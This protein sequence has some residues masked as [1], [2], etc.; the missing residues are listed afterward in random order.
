MHVNQALSPVLVALRKHRSLMPQCR[1]IT[2]R[3]QSGGGPLHLPRSCRRGPGGP[4]QPQGSGSSRENGVWGVPRRVR[5][6]RRAVRVRGDNTGGAAPW[7]RGLGR[8]PQREVK[9]M[10][11]CMLP[12]VAG[13]A[14]CQPEKR[15]VDGSILSLTTIYRRV[16]SAL[17][18][19]NAYPA[20]SCPQPSDDRSCPC[21]T[22]VRHPLSHADRMPCASGSLF[23]R[24]CGRC[25]V[26][27]HIA[28]N[29]NPN[30]NLL[31]S[32]LDQGSVGWRRRFRGTFLPDH[33]VQDPAPRDRQAQAHAEDRPRPLGQVPHLLGPC[34]ID[35][36]VC[37]KPDRQDAH[38]NR[39]H[40]RRQVRVQ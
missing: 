10:P 9:S 24:T 38:G 17:T 34:K 15:K 20:L 31:S 6:G 4:R 3:R 23:L 16:R 37:R 5:E 39:H 29:C 28:V 35:Q 2:I 26:R 33:E 13:R 21:V 7:D 25:T 18:S 8:E 22:V 36:A 19:A 1:R 12:T 14:V 32:P 30:C 40:D 27:R 11:Y